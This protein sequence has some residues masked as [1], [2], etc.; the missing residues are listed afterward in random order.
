MHFIAM[1]R[2]KDMIVNGR[3]LVSLPKKTIKIVKV[4]LDKDDREKYD[5]QVSLRLIFS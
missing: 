5:R 1:R 2:T 3:P 4:D